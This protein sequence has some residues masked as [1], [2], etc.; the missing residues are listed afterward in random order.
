MCSWVTPWADSFTRAQNPTVL[1]YI[2][3]R[4]GVTIQ[5]SQLE[6]CVA[7]IMCSYCYIMNLESIYRSRNTLST[8]GPKM[9]SLVRCLRI[10]TRSVYP[11]TSHWAPAHTKTVPISMSPLLADKEGEQNFGCWTA[12]HISEVRR[13]LLPKTSNT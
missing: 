6:D 4:C 13:H 11:V 7:S 3:A 1:H 2:H 9:A 5:Q 8:G 12:W 10:N